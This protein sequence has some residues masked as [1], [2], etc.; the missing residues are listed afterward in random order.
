MKGFDP[1]TIQA[2]AQLRAKYPHASDPLDALLKS[3]I[4]TDQDNDAVDDKQDS[5]LKRILKTIKQLEPKIR[6]LNNRLSGVEVQINNV[7]KK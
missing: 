2:L 1:E 7:G 3:V 6:D 4:D 5:K